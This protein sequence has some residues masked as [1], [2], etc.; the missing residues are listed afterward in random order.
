MNIRT[1]SKTFL[2][3]ICTLFLLTFSSHSF[4]AHCYWDASLLGATKDGDAHSK[5][6]I[7]GILKDK[8]GSDFSEVWKA[9]EAAVTH[10][11]GLKKGYYHCTWTAG[12]TPTGSS[13]CYMPGAHA[14]STPAPSTSTPPPATPKK[15]KKPTLPPRGTSRADLEVI[16]ADFVRLAETA[17]SAGQSSAAQD[18][19]DYA[20][21]V[22]DM[23]NGL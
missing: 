8:S 2:A 10:Y 13:I 17:A 22:Q 20:A 11:K 14:S 5:K 1:H 12:T 18:Y 4:A 7:Y 23:I 15:P 6:E 21:Q 3:T 9:F 16:Y 19:L